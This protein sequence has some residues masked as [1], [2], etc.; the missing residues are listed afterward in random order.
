MPKK[1][2]FSH[3]WKVSF[4]VPALKNVGERFKTKGHGPVSLLVVDSQIFEK[5]QY[6]SLDPSR[7]VAFPMILNS[8]IW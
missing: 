8:C 3:C 4:A 2:L 7:S 1:I 6:N 5:I